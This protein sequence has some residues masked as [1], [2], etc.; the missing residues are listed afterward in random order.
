MYQ[1]FVRLS[2][3]TKISKIVF[4]NEIIASFCKIFIVAIIFLY[5]KIIFENVEIK[6]E[7]RCCGPK[8]A[9]F[10]STFSPNPFIKFIGQK[11]ERFTP[12]SRES[13]A[14]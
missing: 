1:E 2:Y 13:H 6:Y 9:S 10:D 5:L 11:Y 14:P 8:T 12:E 7:K 4:Y 3:N